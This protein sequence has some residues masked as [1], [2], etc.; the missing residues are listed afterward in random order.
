MDARVK[1]AIEFLAKS[2]RTNS[3]EELARTLHL[4][5]SRLRHLIKAELGMAPGNYER[6]IRM[7]H[8]RSLLEN[9]FL[10]I[11]EVTHEA[12]F[13]DVSHFVR[14]FKKQFGVSPRTY[15][16]ANGRQRSAKAADFSNPGQLLAKTAN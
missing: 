14:G 10:S 4:S 12:G 7:Q 6:G 2:H 9:T 1:L 15:R 16:K 8:A 5:T 3:F 11:K 13:H